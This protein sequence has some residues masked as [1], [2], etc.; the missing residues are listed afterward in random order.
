MQPYIQHISFIHPHTQQRLPI[1]P[2][3]HWQP[4]TPANTPNTQNPKPNH[5]HTEQCLPIRPST[6]AAAAG[7]HAKEVVEEGAHEVVVQEGG[8]VPHLF[9][10]GGLLLVCGWVCAREVNKRVGMPTILQSQ[11]QE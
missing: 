11:T 10:L 4:H 3:A 7:L 9:F 6:L 5:P 8:A 2:R 1:R